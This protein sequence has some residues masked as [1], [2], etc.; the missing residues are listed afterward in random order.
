VQPVQHDPLWGGYLIHHSRPTTVTVGAA[1]VG[2]ARLADLEEM[3]YDMNAYAE[4][5]ARLPLDVE[6]AFSGGEGI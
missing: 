6:M 1:R 3:M 5:N 2:A 4:E